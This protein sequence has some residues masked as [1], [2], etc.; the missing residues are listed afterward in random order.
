MCF[1]IIIAIIIIVL[2]FTNNLPDTFKT[3]IDSSIDDINYNL[4]TLYSKEISI[5]GYFQSWT[6]IYTM[7]EEE[8]GLANIPSYI[9]RIY[10]S[11]ANPNLIYVKGSNT[12]SNTGLDFSVNF[13]LVKNA[14]TFAKN[15]NPKQKFILSVGGATYPWT[16]NTRYQDIIDLIN[17]LNLDGIDIDYE[18]QTYCSNK[19]TDEIKCTNDD[20]IILIISN[21]RKFLDKEQKIGDGKVEDINNGKKTGLKILSVATFSVGAYCT[22]QFPDYKFGPISDYCGMWVNPLLKAGKY[23]DELNIM[24][25][26]AGVNYSALNAFDAFK[27]IF[28]RK[29]RIGLEIPP[30]A[31]G[32]DILSVDRGVKYAEYSMKN[33]G[34]GIFIWSLNKVYNQ[35]NAKAYLMPICK[36]YGLSECDLDIP[37]K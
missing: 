25:Y 4:E 29:I 9:T 33:N 20:D 35:L 30:E 8:F 36:L 28:N 37:M 24:S 26:D 18:N 11:F 32:G 13:S 34:A 7:K 5:G 14:I 23:L 16:S 27:N 19:N 21:M 17:D 10:I 12:F 31:W 2:Y 22:K 6:S 1:F 15:K 3:S